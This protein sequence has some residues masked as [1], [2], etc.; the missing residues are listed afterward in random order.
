MPLRTLV[1]ALRIDRQRV[2][3]AVDLAVACQ[4]VRVM[5]PQKTDVVVA[6][7]PVEVQQTGPKKAGSMLRGGPHGRLHLLLP[8]GNARQQRCHQYTRIDANGHQPFEHTQPLC[9]RRRARLGQAPGSLIHRGH[10][11]ADGD[12]RAARHRLKQ[13]QAAPDQRRLTDDRYR[14]TKVVQRLQRSPGEPVRALAEPA[15]RGQW[16]SPVKRI[17][18][19]MNG[20]TARAAV[21]RRSSFSPSAHR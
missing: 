19:S 6:H 3:A 16:R 5:L 15:D 20:L 8:R 14:C 9:G 7:I 17:P 4:Q 1:H 13:V 18:V 11:H 21:P 12:A 10:A 2:L